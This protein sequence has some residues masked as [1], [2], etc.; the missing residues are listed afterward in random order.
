MR[1]GEEPSIGERLVVEAIETL[2]AEL[3]KENRPPIRLLI[4]D[5]VRASL[6]GSED[7][8]EHVAA[9]LRAVQPTLDWLYVERGRKKKY[10]HLMPYG[11]LPTVELTLKFVGKKTDGKHEGGFKSLTGTAT[12]GGDPTT[13]KIECVI[14]PCSPRLSP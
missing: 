10:A 2:S 13:M 8:S 12:C 11:L 7:N 9:Y 4:I 3:A 6:A 1:E 14:S 5:T